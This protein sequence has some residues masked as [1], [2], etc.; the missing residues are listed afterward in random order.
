MDLLINTY[1]CREIPV[2]K[3][4]VLWAVRVEVQSLPHVGMGCLG[5]G[6]GVQAGFW[7]AGSLLTG[8][9]AR[10]GANDGTNPSPVISVC[11]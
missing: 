9:A 7:A 11:L 4:C 8:Q 5:L 1:H 2:S 6:R 10:R 3:L